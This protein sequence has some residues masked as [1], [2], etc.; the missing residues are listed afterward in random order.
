MKL[1]TPA[2]RRSWALQIACGMANVAFTMGPNYAG[3]CHKT[4]TL[5]HFKTM[6][7]PYVKQKGAS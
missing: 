5:L 6:L 7:F 1:R 3:E 2:S 4:I